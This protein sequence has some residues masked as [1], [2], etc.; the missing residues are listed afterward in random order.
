M[1][2]VQRRGVGHLAVRPHD[3]PHPEP[4]SFS[5]IESR[6]IDPMMKLHFRL[7]PRIP[8]EAVDGLF[9]EQLGG[10]LAAWRADPAMGELIARCEVVD[11]GGV[12]RFDVVLHRLEDG[13]VYLA[14]TGR[15][16]ACFSQGSATE[17]DDDDLVDALDEGLRGL[18]RT[19]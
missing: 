19:R 2:R 17:C 10:R 4:P 12:P 7:L 11:E 5:D 1:Q 9:A 13:P 3:P 15:F 8:L 6:V 18:R 16:V 14:G